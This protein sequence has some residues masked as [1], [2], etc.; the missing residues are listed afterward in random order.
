MPLWGGVCTEGGPLTKKN[1]VP[2]HSMKNPQATNKRKNG[3]IWRLHV[4]FGGKSDFWHLCTIITHP[5]KTSKSSKGKILLV[6]GGEVCQNIWQHM[7]FVTKT[8][9]SQATCLTLMFLVGGAVNRG[10]VPQA[11]Q[12]TSNSETKD[13]FLGGN[14]FV[15]PPPPVCHQ[16]L[17]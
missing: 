14:I 7:A 15:V 1:L 16:K 2:G 17:T 5:P 9:G 10:Q 3:H 4:E 13:S 12:G 6:P 8:L 11:D